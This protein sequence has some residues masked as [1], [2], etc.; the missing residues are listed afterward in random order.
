MFDDL[1]ISATRWLGLVGFGI[2][3]LAC[4]RASRRWPSPW[5]ALSAAQALFFAEIV[6]NLRHRLHDVADAFLQAQQWY[7]RREPLQIALL[8]SLGALVLGVAFWLVTSRR[9]HGWQ[10]TLALAATLVSAALFLLEVVS[11]HAI[12][13][14][15]YTRVGGVLVI[16]LG[17][18][19]LGSIVAIC[20]LLRQRA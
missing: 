3:A 20:A 18:L 6:L 12:D 5:R 15:M 11:L 4:W 10:G 2:A 14:L 9:R 8:A 13:A 16:G 17:W 19:L 7:V 1:H